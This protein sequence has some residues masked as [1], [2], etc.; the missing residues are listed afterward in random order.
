MMQGTAK[1][2]KVRDLPT[3]RAWSFRCEIAGTTGQ[4][5]LQQ[6]E[7]GMIDVLPPHQPRQEPQP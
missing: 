7:I 1:H 4:S 5:M 3:H 6:R 2:A